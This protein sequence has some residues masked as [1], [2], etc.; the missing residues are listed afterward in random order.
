MPKKL[1]DCVSKVMNQGKNRSS[2]YA[3]CAKSTGWVKGKDGTWTKKESTS[4]SKVSVY[5]KPNKSAKGITK[6]VLGQ[7]V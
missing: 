2:A 3:I 7:K 5:V 4:E 6:A 1:E